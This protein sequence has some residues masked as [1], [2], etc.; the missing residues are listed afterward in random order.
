MRFEF[1]QSDETLTTHSGLAL[2]GLLLSKTNLGAALNSTTIPDNLTP[3][4]SHADVIFSYIGLLCQ[5]KSDFD[6]IEPFREDPFFGTAMMLDSAVPANSTLRLRIEKGALLGWKKIVMQATLELLKN[7]EAPITSSLRDLVPLDLDVSPFDNSD[8]K[9][10]G[11]SYTYKGVDGY[12]PIFAY[13]GEEGYGI[14]VELREGKEHSQNN[15][16]SFLRET[17]DNARSVTSSG[18]LVR[19]DSGFDSIENIKVCQEE[20]TDFIIKR[21]L[22]KEE[23]EDWLA[24]AQKGGIRYLERPGKEVY[25]GHT[26]M[27]RSLKEPLRVVYKVIYRTTD[28]NGQILLVPDIE[29]HSYWTSLPDAPEVII[30]QYKNLGT[31]EQFHSELKTELD[32]ERLPSGKFIANELV[33]HLGVLSYNML[34]FIGQQALLVNDT[35]LRKKAERRRVRTVIQ[36]LITLASKLVY[37]ARRYKLRFSKYCPW[38]TTF[39][40][41]YMAIDT[42]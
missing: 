15:T 3:E 27:D 16:P 12:A 21:N 29:I 30:G 2:I 28:A 8:T 33:L 19:M 6:H 14:H 41:I 11:V 37:H 38:L 1:E 35:P 36:N 22:R 24:L 18:L 13:L 34:R 7:N 10:E 4:I 17:I 20:G 26:T 23:P 40:R 25:T 9:K 39:K 32:L 42:T 5:G 31:T